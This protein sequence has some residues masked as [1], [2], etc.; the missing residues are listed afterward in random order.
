MDDEGRMVCS[1][2]RER[3]LHLLFCSPLLPPPRFYTVL[4]R[5]A[6]LHTLHSCQT[7]ACLDERVKG[8]QAATDPPALVIS[9]P[10]PEGDQPGG[11]PCLSVSSISTQK[12]CPWGCFLWA[13]KERGWVLQGPGYHMNL[14]VQAPE[15]GAESSQQ[16]G[17]S[18]R[19][20]SV[21]RAS[22]LACV[23]W[24]GPSLCLPP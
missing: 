5:T 1:G 16:D 4:L 21:F 9:L 14:P 18:S 3:D 6:K 13:L 24:Q 12:P 22:H 23:I 15:V 2:N 8:A 7:A 11:K 20:L 17:M 19:C 10:A